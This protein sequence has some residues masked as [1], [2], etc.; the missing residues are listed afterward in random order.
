MA[1]PIPCPYKGEALG[2]DG[3]SCSSPATLQTENCCGEANCEK[4]FLRPSSDE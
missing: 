3:S 2:G 1:V 4:P